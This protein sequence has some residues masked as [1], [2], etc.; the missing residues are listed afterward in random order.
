[1]RRWCAEKR[2]GFRFVRV[3]TLAKK[4]ESPYISDNLGQNC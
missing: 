4:R 2:V 1:M 3:N